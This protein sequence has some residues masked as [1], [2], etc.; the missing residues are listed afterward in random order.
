MKKNPIRQE[1]VA[2]FDQ[3]FNPTR[4]IPCQ[5]QWLSWRVYAHKR[6]RIGRDGSEVSDQFLLFADGMVHE[7]LVDS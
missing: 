1:L 5:M 6:R 3:L 4:R 7:L 2:P